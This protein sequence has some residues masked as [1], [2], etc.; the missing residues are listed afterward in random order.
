MKLWKKE[1]LKNKSDFS[2][3]LQAD[4]QSR[5]DFFKIIFQIKT[6]KCSK[7]ILLL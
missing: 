3:E 4:L 5:K 1:K 7:S 6:N 2:V